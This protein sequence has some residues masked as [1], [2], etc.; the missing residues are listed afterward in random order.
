MFQFLQPRLFDITV[1]PTLLT[2][3]YTLQLLKLMLISLYL[4]TCTNAKILL[5]R[6]FFILLFVLFVFGWGNFP[7]ITINHCIFM[8]MTII[9]RTNT[10]ILLINT[11]NIYTTTPHLTHFTH[12]NTILKIQTS[13]WYT[14]TTLI[15][16]HFLFT[17]ITLINHLQN[18]TINFAAVTSINISIGWM[19]INKIF[20]SSHV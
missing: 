20:K 1:L 10:L 9:I 16:I 7:I 6:Q 13:P 4:W 12:F 3:F 19:I 11:T 2:K 18:I 5:F 8:F 14:T 17:I 15:Q